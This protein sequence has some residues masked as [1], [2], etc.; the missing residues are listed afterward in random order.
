MWNIVKNDVYVQKSQK[1][2]LLAYEMYLYETHF[3]FT[4]LGSNMHP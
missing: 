2:S 3:S 1:T 4:K